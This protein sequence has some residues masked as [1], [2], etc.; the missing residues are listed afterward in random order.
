MS[1]IISGDISMIEEWNRLNSPPGSLERE[2]EDVGGEVSQEGDVVG[3]ACTNGIS[4]VQF[5]QEASNVSNV[6]P[7]D[8]IRPLEASASEFVPQQTPSLTTPNSVTTSRSLPVAGHLNREQK[9]AMIRLMWELY[10][11]ARHN[12]QGTLLP[13]ARLYSEKLDY[14]QFPGAH[15]DIPVPARTRYKVYSEKTLFGHA[16][17]P[18]FVAGTYYHGPNGAVF[19]D[20][21]SPPQY[22]PEVL[23]TTKAVYNQIVPAVLK[24]LGQR[25]KIEQPHLEQFPV[26][27]EFV[28]PLKAEILRQVH[29]IWNGV[30]TP[31]NLISD[32][33]PQNTGGKMMKL[34]ALLISMWTSSMVPNWE[35]NDKQGF[36]KVKEFIR[37]N[38]HGYGESR[39]TMEEIQ[40]QRELVKELN[41]NDFSNGRYLHAISDIR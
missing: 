36:D 24:K 32:P 26:L 29:L 35:D 16:N 41:L 19:W 38:P 8:D 11:R 1:H 12:D 40:I 17:V 21:G 37:N 25:M 20:C 7:G 5:G 15:P 28:E 10:T 39:S 30:G 9:D 4:D 34:V 23:R 33:D 3:N 18:E 2:G 27:P 31:S 6:V 13:A 22:P 14:L